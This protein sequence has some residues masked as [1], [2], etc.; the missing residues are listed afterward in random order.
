MPT[1]PAI[2]QIII[3]ATENIS[4]D[5]T[6]LVTAFHMVT[7]T[8]LVAR[9]EVAAVREAVTVAVA[10]KAAKTWEAVAVRASSE[11]WTIT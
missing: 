9:E 5:F 4:A 6:K 7:V 3:K 11:P 2:S 8:A 10:T 1:L